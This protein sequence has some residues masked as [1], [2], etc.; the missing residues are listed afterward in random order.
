MRHAS[1]DRH[2]VLQQSVSCAVAE[3]NLRQDRRKRGRR[4]EWGRGGGECDNCW[5]RT[6]CV[7]L[8][9]LPLGRP[10]LLHLSLSVSAARR[11]LGESDAPFYLSGRAHRGG[12]AHTRYC[13]Y[14]HTHTG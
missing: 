8:A 9:T 14:T 2:L 4:S 11:S 3:R 5:M 12:G 6:E 10:R 7:R 1:P 13:T